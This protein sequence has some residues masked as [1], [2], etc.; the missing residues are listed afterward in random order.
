[1][2][3]FQVGEFKTRFSEI[4]EWVKSGEEILLTYGKRREKVAVLVPYAAYQSNSIKVGIFQGERLR[5]HDDFEMTD[6]ELLAL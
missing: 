6:E 1:M 5:I 4:I 3:T 2:K